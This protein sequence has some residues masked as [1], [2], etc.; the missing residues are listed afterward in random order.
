MLQRNLCREIQHYWLTCW[1]D[2]GTPADPSVLLRFLLHVRP[3][4]EEYRGPTV[5]HCRFDSKFITNF[6]LCNKLRCDGSW[7]LDRTW[8]EIGKKF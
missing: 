1:P 7:S 3:D 2:H 4:M 8:N 6:S 5:V